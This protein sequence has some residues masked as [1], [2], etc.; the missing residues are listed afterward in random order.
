MVHLLDLLLYATMVT[1]GAAIMHIIH[2]SQERAV[3]AEHT[4]TEYWRRRYEDLRYN[5]KP[6]P[7]A[8]LEEAP[9][10]LQLNPKDAWASRVDGQ[11]RNGRRA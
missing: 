6:S 4:K 9:A 7:M 11:V 8:M 10:P 5:S 1:L 2:G 3:R